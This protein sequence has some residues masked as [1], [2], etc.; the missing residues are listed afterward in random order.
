MELLSIIAIVLSIIAISKANDVLQRVVV[1]EKNI[2]DKNIL[3]STTVQESHSQY[4]QATII[5]TDD[6]QDALSSNENMT[7]EKTVENGFVTWIKEDWLLKLGGTLVIIGVLFFLSLA[8]DEFGAQG[9]A[10]V[11]YLFGISLMVFGFKYAKKE[12]IGGSAIHLVGAIVVILTTY[13]AQLPGYGYNVFDPHFA[14]V[15]MFLTVVCVALTAYAHDRAPLAHVGLL[16]ASLVPMLTGTA[17]RTFSITLIYLGVVILGVL[18]LALVTKWRTLVLLSLVITC[19]YSALKISGSFGVTTVTFTESYLLVVFGI[20]FY[21]TSLFSILRS[22]GEVGKIDGFVALL[23][24]VFA[25]MWIMHQVPEHLVSIIVAIIGFA[26]S[27]GFFFVYKVTDRYTAFLVYGGAGLGLLTTSIIMELSGPVEAIVVLLIGGGATIMTYYL[28]ED[29]NVTKIVGLINIVPVSYVFYSIVSIAQATRRDMIAGET[30]EHF[31]VLIVASIIYFVLYRYCKDKVNA[32]SD[33]ALAGVLLLSIVIVW[34]FLHM[35]IGGQFA[36]FASIFL[37]TV[38]GLVTLFDGTKSG[39]D[40]KVRIS[41]IWL[42]VVALFA[43]FSAMTVDVGLAV[44][45]CVVIGILLLSST[46]IIRKVTSA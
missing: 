19:L 44:L 29:E 6:T 7:P 9:K 36:T 5:Q 17:G 22:K 28:S 16:I 3:S 34:Q 25:L 21:V 40:M 38:T 12:I 11:G 13:V 18:W 33:G 46:F 10:I 15:L 1:L 37:Y 4:S 42:S 27:V 43:I 30:W 35:T 20:L 14:M 31:L 45:L 41:K 8:Y 32:L 24:V 23:N 26:Y 2:K 39:N